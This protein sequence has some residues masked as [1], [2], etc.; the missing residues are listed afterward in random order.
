[1]KKKD[2]E[3][4]FRTFKNIKK[5]YENVFINKENLNTYWFGIASLPLIYFSAIVVY[6]YQCNESHGKKLFS[7]YEEKIS[8]DSFNK[9]YIKIFILKLRYFFFKNLF[10]LKNKIY[11][12]YSK[13]NLTEEFCKKKN[14]SKL[15]LTLFG[16]YPKKIL[17]NKIVI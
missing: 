12:I 2:K 8:L 3:F 11:V 1:M 9:S 17:I 14:F 7:Y 6:L 13:N 4:F 5:N 10:F 15:K 16:I